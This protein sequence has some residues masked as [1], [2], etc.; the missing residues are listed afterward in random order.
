[1]RNSTKA[2]TII[3]RHSFVNNLDTTRLLTRGWIAD[4]ELGWFHANMV[5]DGSMLSEEDCS[6]SH[7]FVLHL[8]CDLQLMYVET[9]F[10]SAVCP[11]P[12][13]SSITIPGYTI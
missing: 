12:A 6:H 11:G 13:E 7:C 9:R 1:M 4:V 2:P 10:H 5:N 8:Q 3:T